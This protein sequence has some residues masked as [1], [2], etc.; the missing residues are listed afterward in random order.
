MIWY[1]RP[2][3]SIPRLYSALTRL[4]FLCFRWTTRTTKKT[5]LRRRRK[6]GR[7]QLWRE[8][9][10]H[11]GSRSTRA[12]DTEGSGSRRRWNPRFRAPALRDSMV[13]G[14]L[15]SGTA[16]GS[17]QQRTRQGTL[18]HSTATTLPCNH[19]GTHRHSL[20]QIREP[21]PLQSTLR[22]LKMPG[23]P[24]FPSVNSNSA[25]RDRQ[26]FDTLT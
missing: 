19:I 17:D 18:R 20:L 4:E 13:T 7:D 10:S 12:E 24:S 1:A 26:R 2:L 3:C 11:C 22:I 23:L 15:Y 8:D 5:E 16:S 6:R 9:G 14:D 21:A 25:H